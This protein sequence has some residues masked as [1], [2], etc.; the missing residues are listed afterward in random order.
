MIRSRFP[1]HAAA[2]TEGGDN[3]GGAAAAAKEEKTVKVTVQCASLGEGPETYTRGQ[4]FETTES[5]AK[6]LGDLV[7]PA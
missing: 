2:K 4:T 6:A 1:L 5:R 3:G 7:K